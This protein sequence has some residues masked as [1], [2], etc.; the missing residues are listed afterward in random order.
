[1]IFALASMYSDMLLLGLSSSESSDLIDVG[2]LVIDF[3]I[4]S[5]SI[6]QRQNDLI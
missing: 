6:P 3:A 1:M 5:W 4:K 2:W